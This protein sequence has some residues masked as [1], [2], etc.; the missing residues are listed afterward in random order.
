MDH[1]GTVKEISLFGAKGRSAAGLTD[2]A[3]GEDGGGNQRWCERKELGKE[4]YRR[5][6]RR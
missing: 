4:G 5:K 6:E 2:G 1:F 3:K